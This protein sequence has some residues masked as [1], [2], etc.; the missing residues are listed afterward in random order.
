MLTLFFILILGLI[1]GSF[2]SMLTYRLP[3]KLSFSGRSFCDNCKQK[4]PWYNNIPVFFYLFSGGKS[5][6]CQ[7][8]ISLRYPIIE[9]TTALFFVFTYILFEDKNLLFYLSMPFLIWRQVFGDLAYPFLLIITIFLLALSIIDLEFGILPDV[10]LKFLSFPVFIFLLLS[11]SP[12]FFNGIFF[13]F[14]SFCFF[15]VIY[16][17]TQKR[18]WV[19]GM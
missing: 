13:G 15:L 7:K 8:K 5:L 11:P 3:R 17:I 1:S 4:I 6:C 10:L 14:I 12:G 18:E 2:I 19:L 16:L 9:I